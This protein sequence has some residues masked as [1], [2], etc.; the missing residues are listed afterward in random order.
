M[1]ASQGGGSARRPATPRLASTAFDR[2]RCLPGRAASVTAR[3]VCG[4]D[5]SAAPAFGCSLA[6]SIASVRRRSC[7]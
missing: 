1:R 4:L 3:R 7:R 5:G 6:A 2:P